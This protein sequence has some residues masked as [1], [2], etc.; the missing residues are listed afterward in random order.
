MSDLNDIVRQN[1]AE[2]IMILDKLSKTENSALNLTTE[3]KELAE[4]VDII[5]KHREDVGRKLQ[6][7]MYDLN[8]KTES[9]V[10]FQKKLRVLLISILGLMVISQPAILPMLLKFVM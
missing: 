10:S 2:H 6:R 1:T 8:E 4:E 3:V 7:Q 5:Q 9:I